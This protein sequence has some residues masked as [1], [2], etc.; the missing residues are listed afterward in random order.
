MAIIGNNKYKNTYYL[1]L[2]Y[3][4]SVGGVGL[5]IIILKI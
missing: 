2:F 4:Q 5:S 1:F 3:T